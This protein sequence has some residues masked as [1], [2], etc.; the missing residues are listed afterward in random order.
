VALAVLAAATAPFVLRGSA[1]RGPSVPLPGPGAVPVAYH[2]V[3]RV[4]T[5]SIVSTEEL[6]VDRP[7]EAED[8]VFGGPAA[9]GEP[10]STVVDRLGR[11]LVHAGGAPA[12]FTPP[13][14]PTRFDV[15]LDAVAGA[16]IAARALVPRGSR[17]VAGRPCRV[18]RSA[19]SLLSTALAGRPTAGDHV[20]TCVD[21]QG[22]VLAERRVV[23]GKVVQ[24]RRA[25]TVASGTSASDH[26]YRT[27]GAHLPLRQGG[28]A[29]VTISDT[30]RPP[31]LTFWEP[32]Q[33]PAGFSHLGRFAVVAPQ[34]S[35]GT[36]GPPAALSTAIDDV[37]GRGPDVI[38]V[39]QGPAAGAR[40]LQ[41]PGGGRD[42]DLGALGRGRLVLSAT[43]PSVTA[44]LSNNSFVAVSGTVPPDEL[45]AVA[46]AL[47]PQPPGTIV[48]VPDLTSDGT[49]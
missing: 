39:E 24:E 30:S 31:G 40:A 12:V 14:A 23:A 13:P 10:V 9:R 46:R 48:T 33:A 16:A 44:V 41:P 18:Y 47:Q 29:V 4:T 45:V 7:F 22:L 6:W 20:D 36:S 27:P 38:V 43:A 37:Y 17:V 5:G 25:T 32:S 35:A 49:P 19:Q 15:R 26:S 21:A 2:V 28:G 8:V 11:Q 42:V 34:P 3:Y 1:S